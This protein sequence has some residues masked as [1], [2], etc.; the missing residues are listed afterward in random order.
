MDAIDPTAGFP[1]DEANA[2]KAA[3]TK[4]MVF[5]GFFIIL[6]AFCFLCFYA[7]SMRKVRKS[8]EQSLLGNQMSQR[9][10]EFMREARIARIS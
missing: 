10:E 3:K 7:S 6:C 4:F 9:N 1:E 8:H 2:M 5:F